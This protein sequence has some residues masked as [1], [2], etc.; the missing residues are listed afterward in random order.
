[1]QANAAPMARKSTRDL[2]ILG[3]LFCL[4]LIGLIGVA[5]ATGWEESWRQIRALTGWQLAALLIL[6]LFNY[7]L[8]SYRWHQFGTRLGLGLPFKTSL[9]H[10]FGG[11]AMSITPGRVGE[12]VRLR[13]MARASGWRI[14]GLSP[15]P[16]VDRA[17][18]LAGLGILLAVGVAFSSAGNFGAI[19]V[20]SLAIGAAVLVTRPAVLE[21][22]ITGL[23][24]IIHRAPRLFARLR[25]AARSIAV[26]SSPTTAGLGIGLSTTAWLAECFALYLLLKWM[27]APID[28][29]SAVV[30]FIFSTL[31]GGLTGAPGGLGGAEAAMV[32]LLGLSGVPLEIALPATAVIRLTTLWFAILLGLAAFPLA[33]RLSNRAKTA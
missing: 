20:A 7:L 1:M 33:E 14:E 17:F 11:F 22:I 15:L 29:A 23:W 25:R 10:F 27:G 19:A 32:F 24:R 13:W 5:M 8:R 21:M 16:L 18:D 9:V 4:F 12:L 3:G 2:W 26:F 6:S 31:A 30:I 28:L